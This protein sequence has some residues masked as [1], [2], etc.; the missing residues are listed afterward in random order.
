MPST[1]TRATRLAPS[2]SP[3][4]RPTQPGHPSTTPAPRSGRPAGPSVLISG[5]SVA[6]PA[7]AYWLRRYG[8]RPTVVEVAPA[9][10]D[11]GFAVDFRG[12]AHLTVLERMGILDRI[13]QHTTGGGSPMTFIDTQGRELASLPAE[14]A[15]G[16]LEILRST[17]S[18]LLYEH[19]AQAPTP[20]HRPGY[21]TEA[22]P[23]TEY[24][25]GDSITSMTETATGVEVTFERSAP[26]IFDLVIGADGLHSTVRRL[27]FGP[28][29][30]FVGHLGYYVAG[31]DLTAGSDISD[32]SVGYGEPGRMVSVGR[33]PR[34]TTEAGYHGEVFVVFA[35][36][37]LAYDRRDPQAQKQLIAQAYAGAGWRTAE[38]IDTLWE[39]QN[40]YFDSISRVDIPTWSKGRITL[41]GDAAYGATL[42]GMGTG[43]AIVGA[44]VLAGELAAADGDHRRAFSRYEQLM[45]PY[46]TQCQQGGQGVGEFLAPRT[47]E[48]IETRNHMLNDPDQLAAMFQQGHDISADITLP[49]YPY[50]S[51]HPTQ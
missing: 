38:L 43:A 16:E 12:A 13:R 17:L 51:L 47:A 20:H 25:F 8:Y 14:F 48:G 27:A 5:A 18:R 15:A 46:V 19:S 4:V 3:P 35:S 26:R 41:L 1:T 37:K 36:K 45:R 32:R 33:M 22:T 44:Y 28:E 49:L 21:T 6:G 42:G 9:L 23:P 39:A 29:E 30:D 7:L 34:R 40:L 2:P 10:R 24:V 31:W 11:G 50:P